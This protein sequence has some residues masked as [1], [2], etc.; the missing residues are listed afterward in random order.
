MDRIER[1]QSDRV[2]SIFFASKQSVDCPLHH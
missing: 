1:V 2:E